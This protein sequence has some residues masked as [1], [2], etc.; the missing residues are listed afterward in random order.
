[1]RPEH[2]QAWMD[3]SIHTSEYAALLELIRE[4][5]VSAG[6]TQMQMAKK[7]GR[8]QSFVTKFEIGER[9][10]DVVQLRTVCAVLGT[11]LAEFVGRW[12]ERLRG[13]RKGSK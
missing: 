13:R 7:L 11:R 3:K 4:A 6:L 2:G 8:S 12:E 1:M 10:L 5:R 9:R